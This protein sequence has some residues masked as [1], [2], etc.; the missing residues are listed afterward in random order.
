M[1][2]LGTG[3]CLGWLYPVLLLLLVAQTYTVDLAPSQ[4][5]KSQ[6]N[7][8][9]LV[10]RLHCCPT[11][12]LNSNLP[13]P[14]THP[15]KTLLILPLTSSQPTFSNKQTDILTKVLHREENSNTKFKRW[16]DLVSIQYAVIFYDCLGLP[17]RWTEVLCTISFWNCK[18]SIEI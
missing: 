15:M 3:K 1:V 4:P 16:L 14:T 11:T 6:H 18:L 17:Y 5:L 12:F 13:S 8:S 10:L 9:R 7:P 2:V